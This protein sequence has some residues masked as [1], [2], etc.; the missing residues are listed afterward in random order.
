MTQSTDFQWMSAARSH[1]GL[2]R[3]VN[4]DACLAQPARCLWVVADGM[5][6]H[7]LGD[8]ASRL[9]IEALDGMPPAADLASY[10][11]EARSRLQM[12][13]Q[14]LRAE[15][16]VRN[17][18]IIGSTV[19]VLLAFGRRCA[20]LWAGDSRLY[21][22]RNGVLTQLTRDHSQYEEMRASGY[23]AELTLTL[24]ARNLITRAVG[25][26]EE[27]EID[28]QAI[29]VED[30]DTFLLCSDGLSN[31][32]SDPDICGALIAG[33]CDQAAETL[34]ALALQGGGRDNVSAVVVRADDVFGAD[35]TVLNPAL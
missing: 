24:A 34:I 18:H 21:L 35:K 15:A 30:G 26:G 33:N 27:L 3:Q 6:G 8:L 31:E 23:P 7:T 28:E 12:V 20:Y 10:V 17:A 14:Q 9:I 1:V 11:A 25:A 32:V 19:V 5:G 4:E 2:V 13:N 22:C 16:I 29:D